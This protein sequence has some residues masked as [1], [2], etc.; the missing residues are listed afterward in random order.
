MILS[1][2]KITTFENEIV[3]ECTS[4]HVPYDLCRQIVGVIYSHAEV[5]KANFD[6]Y[7]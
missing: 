4:I 6:R 3:V 7:N 2:H 5:L 1:L